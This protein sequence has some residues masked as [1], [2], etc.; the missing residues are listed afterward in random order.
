M[1]TITVFRH[2]TQYPYTE[3][4]WDQGSRRRVYAETS[5]NWRYL[6]YSAVVF[7]YRIRFNPKSIQRVVA[8]M[9]EYVFLTATRTF[10]IQTGTTMVSGSTRTGTTSRTCGMT[11]VLL[12][13][14]SRN[15]LHFSPDI[16]SGEFCCS[17]YIA[18]AEGTFWSCP[19]HPPSIFPI[20]FKCSESAIYFL[21]SRDFVSQST[22]SKI[23]SVSIFRI[24]NRTYGVFSSRERN[25]AMATDSIASIKRES[26][27]CPREYLWSLGKVWW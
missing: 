21:S 6:A 15:S 18:L 23:F 20:S 4:V 26:I 13:F 14:L 24:A 5:K 11:T 22:I 25:A 27:L 10:S 16:L 1:R 19:I 2:R 12:P 8:R 3:G 17:P 9:A 7:R